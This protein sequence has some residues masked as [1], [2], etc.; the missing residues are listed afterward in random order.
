MDDEVYKGFKKMRKKLGKKVLSRQHD[1][2]RGPRQD[3]P[4]V[5]PE[6]PQR[7]SGSRAAAQKSA[8]PGHPRFLPSLPP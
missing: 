1:R 8:E 2:G 3:G 5:R 7:G 4:P 6:G